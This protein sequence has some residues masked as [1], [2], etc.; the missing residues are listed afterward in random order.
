VRFL[1]VL[2]LVGFASSVS[3]RAADPMLPV[4]AADL[5][6]TLHTAALLSSAYS[7]P[8]AIMQIALGPAG[9]AFG[10]VPMIRLSLAMVAASLV[11]T[12]L[13]PSYGTVLAARAVAGAF[14]GGLTPMSLALIGDRVALNLRQVAIAR[15]LIAAI[16]GQVLGAAVSGML[17]EI[18]GWRAVFALAAAVVALAELATILFLDGSG[19]TR[20]RLSFRGAL[21]GYRMVLANPMAVLIY[22]AVLMEGAVVLGLLPFVA[23]LVLR[24]GAAGAL[25]GGI[26]IAAFA[27]G[28]MAYGFV[29]RS[30]MAALGQWNMMRLGGV[31]AGASV[32]AMALPVPWIALAGLFFVTGFG[33]YMMHNTLQTLATE[34][35]P[36]ARASAIGLLATAFYTG[37]GVGPVLGGALVAAAGL[38]PLFLC[39]GAA[40]IVLGPIAAPLLRRRSAAK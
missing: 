15:Y 2:C 4:M 21:R 28:G 16:F 17:V 19:E 22:A 10:R 8:Y 30:L 9:D 7:F 38:G 37:Q 35:A 1:L 13:A 5:H 23:A 14:A 29:V 6:V 39:F 24:H 34:L 27:V 11:L 20:S 33:F 3:W 32:M 36:T 12:A 18:V 40:A 26:V 25:E 31:L